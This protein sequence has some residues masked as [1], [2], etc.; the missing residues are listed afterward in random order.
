MN[1]DAIKEKLTLY[2]NIF[3]VFW[4]SFFILGGGLYTIIPHI[5]NLF[6]LIIFFAGFIF[7]I[8]LFTFAVGL[9]FRCKKLIKELMEI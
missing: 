4:T 3:T 2:R 7:E 6:Y 5:K 8:I 9:I 1:E